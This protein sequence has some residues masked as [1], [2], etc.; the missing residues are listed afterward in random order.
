MTL[1][2]LNQNNNKYKN[3]G[4]TGLSNL[5]NTCFL[6]SCVQLLSH[7]YELNNILEKEEYKIHLKKNIDTF[8]LL[9]WDNLRKMMW[10]ENCIISPGKFVK[11]VQ[12]LAR[13]KNRQLF[14][15]FAQNDLPEFLIFILD[16]FH[17]ALSREVKMNIKGKSKNNTDNIAIKCFE[18]IKNMYS[19][20]Y[21]EIFDLF[22]G[23]HI[24][25]LT[26]INN[27]HISD[28]P[29]PF[30]LLSLPMPQNNKMPSLIDC[31]NC[32][33]ENENLSGEN[34]IYN[35]KTNLK[36]DA[37]RGIKFWSLPKILTI[38]LKRFNHK[39]QK[40]QRLVTFPLEELNLSKYVIGYNPESYIYDLF[41][42]ANH[43]GSSFGG[44]Y[45]SYVKNANNKW[46][47]FN[48]TNVSEV[49]NLN[50]L[51]SPKAYCF[52]YRKRM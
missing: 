51:I 28:T 22:Y 14:S 7:T 21:S 2:Y 26:T 44:H 3:K 35:E 47:L 10:Q 24:S 6:N 40:D 25:T 1:Y 15:G 13:A 8:L 39:N 42:I 12:Q 31:F 38:D 30:M 11:C 4:L 9:E 33:T 37:I 19:K 50:N 27:K 43:S 20:E 49:T 34:G 5:G 18:M 32:Y 41:G 46:Y 29:E 23:I 17:N 45:T 48:D 36:E 16:T 52:F